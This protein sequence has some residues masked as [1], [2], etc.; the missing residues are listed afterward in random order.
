MNISII[1][2]AGEGTRMKSKLPKVLHKVCGKPLLEYVIDTCIGAGIEKNVV[3]IGHG[4][5][6]VKED[7]KEKQIIFKSQPIGEDAPYGTGFAVMQGLDEV[8]ED[9]N[10][11][12]LCGDTP[13]ITKETVKELME[14]HERGNFHGTVLSAILDDATGY[15][16]I[17]RENSGAIL[18]IVEHKDATEEEKNIKEINSGMYC[19]NG[20]ALKY[21]LDKIDNN[22]S[23]GEYYLTDVISILKTEGYN[24]GAYIVEDSIE[25]HGVNSRVQLAFSED[26]MRKRINEKFMLEGVTII[27]PQNTYIQDG[28]KIGKDTII[29]PNVIIEGNSI[30]GEDCVIRSNTRIVNS[31]IGERV[32][33]ESSLIEDSIVEE[34]C[35]IGPFSHLRPKSHLGHNVKIGNFVE[36]KNSHIDNNS[37]ASHLAYIGDAKVG[38]NV[39][40]GCG[41]IFVNYDG[42]KKQTTIVGDNAFIGSNSNLVAPVVVNDW[43]YVAAGSTITKEVEEGSLSITRA[44]QVNIEGW[45]NRKGLKNKK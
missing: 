37:K 12:I 41:V 21:A 20:K 33:V 9:C 10:V 29:Y 7:F 18:K 38:K 13:L 11:I 5:D 45:V 16:R 8:E 4:G 14:Y 26:V 36:V 19:F 32:E 23:Q 1:L 3:I 31:I 39:N 30:I 27:D 43:G 42:I 2:A 15:G 17:V 40:I 22:N 35:H 6:K 28:V 25:I 34:S 24:V 44:P